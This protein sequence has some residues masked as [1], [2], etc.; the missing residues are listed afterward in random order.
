M[1][2]GGVKFLM[3][4]RQTPGNDFILFQASLPVNKSL[5]FSRELIFKLLSF[6]AGCEDKICLPIWDVGCTPISGK[7]QIHSLAYE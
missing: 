2:V 3:Q 5:G 6:I 7:Q 1:S 4:T